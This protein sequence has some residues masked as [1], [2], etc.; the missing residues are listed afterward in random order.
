MRGTAAIACVFVAAR[1]VIEVLG[2]FYLSPAISALARGGSAAS[3]LPYMAALQIALGALIFGRA[4]WDAKLSMHAVFHIRGAVYDRLQNPGLSFHHKMTSGALINRA[5]SDLQNVRAFLNTSV[6]GGLDVILTVMAYFG[7]LLSRSP[8]LLVAAIVPIPLWCALVWSFSRR[9]QPLFRSQQEASDQVIGTLN[10]NV[11]GV[12]VIRAF[13]LNDRERRK[14]SALNGKLLGRVLEIV[15]YQAVLTPSLKFIA[16]LAHIGLFVSACALIERG[17][18][19]VGDLMILGVAMGAILGKL[20]LVNGMIEA[21]QKAV[22]SA[23]RLFEV[24]DAPVSETADAVARS[25][26][27]S[28]GG[29]ASRVVEGAIR[30]EQVTF[31][32]DPRNPV[33]HGIDIEI[34]ARQVTAIVGPTGS[35]KTTLAGLIGRFY[36][37]QHG[38]IRVDGSDLREHRLKDLRHSVGF[39]FQETFLFTETIRNNIRYGRMDVSDAMLKA[40]ARA[41]QADEFI[42]SLPQGY[43]TWLGESG[44]QL[45]GGQRQRLALARAL[46]YDPRILILDDA[47]AALDATTERSVL[48][49]LEPIFRDR[50]V[51][52]IAHRLGAL[53][54]ADQVLVMNDGRIEQAGAPSELLARE[55]RLRDIWRLHAGLSLEEVTS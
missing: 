31:G 3:V 33:L 12:H 5:L 11:N 49:M 22:V 18:M 42:E 10:E 48:E 39:V 38:V 6:L 2:V 23:R 41:A 15:R 21:Y 35:G 16:G 40:A 19:Q 45:S 53:R 20:Q 36:D 30:F 27:S 26:A 37:P 50:T 43:D 51:I 47:T 1:I 29:R 34:P 52:V 44:V 8:W 28:P 25:G 17:K 55:G 4:V 9:V 54:L 13:G 46:V 14:F 24:L 32:Y 7:L